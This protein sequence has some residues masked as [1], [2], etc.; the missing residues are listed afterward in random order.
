MCACLIAAKSVY[1][2]HESG[3]HYIQYR[4]TSI[5]HRD[6][7]LS[8]IEKELYYLWNNFKFIISKEEKDIYQVFTFL[9]NTIV[10]LTNYSIFLGR[11]VIIY[12]HIPM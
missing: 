4:K 10:A 8:N 9:M 3:Y 11:N 2:I 12:I 5:T 7:N 6:S 1:V